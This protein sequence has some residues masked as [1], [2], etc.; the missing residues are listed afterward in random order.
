MCLLTGRAAVTTAK[1]ELMFWRIIGRLACV[2]VVSFTHTTAGAAQI[3]CEDEVELALAA[4]GSGPAEEVNYH[5]Q[6]RWLEV[7][8]T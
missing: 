4:I 6:R 8:C 5:R 1:R 3:P 7:S 2:A